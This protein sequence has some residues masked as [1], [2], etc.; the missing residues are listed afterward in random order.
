MDAS[1][2]IACCQLAPDVERPAGNP[3]LARRAIAD[4]V[5]KGAQIVVLPEL[6]NSGYVFGSKEEARAA[7]EP[8]DGELLQTWADEAKQSDAVII[9]GF[10][11]LAPDG[12]LYNSMALV[13][14]EG[15]RAV[16]RK[17]HLWNQEWRWFA[18]GQDRAPVIETRYGRIGLAICYD[19][20]FP[21]LTRGVALAGAEL[22]ALPANW[23]HDA[24]PPNGR[25]ILHSLAAVTAYFNKVFVAVCDRC[26]TERGVEFEGGSVIADP[27]GALRAGPIESRGAQ[28]IAAT[29]D[30]TTARDK[31]TSSRNDAFADRRPES[32][33]GALATP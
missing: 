28:T 23:P 5:Q 29:C 14:G 18:P 4:A 33:A 22:I 20:E 17:L 19:I 21:E 25:P 10:A 16:Y 12:T 1:V 8:A 2:R 3:D 26:G 7:A 30:L 24:D 6:C 27:H 15:V 11:E 9:G 13:D 31:R 32:Y